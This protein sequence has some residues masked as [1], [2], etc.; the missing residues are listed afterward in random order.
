MGIRMVKSTKISNLFKTT[1]RALQYKNF[2]LFWFGQCISLTGTWMQRTAQTWLVYT[3]TKSPM[4]VGILG[5]CQFMPLLLFSL[6][7]GVLVDRFSKK[8]ILIFT[9]ILFMLQAVVMTVLTYTGQIKYWHILILSVIFGL[10]QTLDMPARQSFFIDLVGTENLTNAISLNSTIVNLARIVGPAVSG[11]IMVKYGTV[12]CFFINAVSFI[13]VIAGIILIKVKENPMRR[14]NAHILPDI[15]DGI[16]YIKKSETLVL[17]VLVMAVVCTFAMNNDVIIPVFA[18]EVL[19]R[20]ADGYSALLS[21]AGLGAFISAIMMAYISKSGVKNNLLLISGT[22]TAILQIL[23][24]FTSQY[25]IIVPLIIAVGFFNLIFINIA[26][27]I[28]QIHSSN[29]YRGRVM[30]VYSFLNMGSTP[31]GNFCSGLVMENM[32]GGFGFVFCGASTL[33][34]LAAIF[35]AKHRTVHRWLRGTES[36]ET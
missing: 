7:A 6:F 5:V 14:V 17:N 12:F 25:F 27:S 2:R 26:N 10:T 18:K 29:E 23:T 1:F 33:L 22:A 31:I 28:F 15:M 24:V 30:S 34:L 13:P 4:M 36:A 9:Q 8:K 16:R 21:F 32:G 3:V 11:I 20:G 19:G 35:T